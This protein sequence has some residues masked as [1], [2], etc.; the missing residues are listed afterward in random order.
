M[1]HGGLSSANNREVAVWDALLSMG[2]A[3]CLFHLRIED[4]PA[5]IHHI[6]EGQ[7]RI[8]H[9]HVL[10]LCS[11]HHR[12]GTAQHPSRHSVNGC[13]GGLDIFERTYG[14]EME[15]VLRCEEWI[16]QPYVTGLL[17]DEQAPQGDS[18][19]TDTPAD[20][21]RTGGV[22]EVRLVEISPMEMFS[23]QVRIHVMHHRYRL[24]DF[25]NLNAKGAID[26]LVQAGL[27]QNDSPKYV[28]G[29]ILHDQVKVKSYDDEKTVVTIEE[30]M[31]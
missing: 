27:L 24:A 25:D 3:V 30:V 15:L 23:R 13:H 4:T 20:S 19:H 18:D 11:I 1:A 17:T 29:P 9:S 8:S 22:G 16:N 5:E 31:S 10:P 6:L 14:T 7:R 28:Q 21:E 12:Q 26:G 2:C